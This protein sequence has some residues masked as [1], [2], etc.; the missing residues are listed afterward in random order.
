MA[1]PVERIWIHPRQH[2]ISEEQIV[3]DAA[4]CDA[5]GRAFGRYEDASV[6]ADGIPMLRDLRQGIVLFIERV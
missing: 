6:H 4:N 1:R 5:V 3:T 2:S